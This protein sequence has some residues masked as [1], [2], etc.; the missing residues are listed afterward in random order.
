M[1]KRPI[2][3]SKSRAHSFRDRIDEFITFHPDDFLSFDQF[4]RVIDSWERD[5]S[6]EEAYQYYKERFFQVPGTT[7]RVQEPTDLNKP[8]FRNPSKYI[9]NQ[10][11]EIQPQPTNSFPMKDNKKYQLH[12]IGPRGTYMIDLMFGENGLVYL[13]G[14]NVN[15]RYG[16][17]ELTNMIQK[18]DILK[19]NAKTTTG[20]I[21]ALNKMVR[22]VK[23]MNPITNLIGD[24]EGA[25]TSATAKNFYKEN[26]IN[27]NPVPRMYVDGK[28]TTNPSHSS[29]A[30]VDRFIRTIRDMLYNANYKMTPLAVKAMVNQYNNAPHT[31]LSNV[32]G[33]KVS[34][35]MV[36]QDINKEEYIVMRINKANIATKLSNGYLLNNNTQV[37]VYNEK[38][39]FGKRRQISNI[40]EIIERIGSFY[41][42]KIKTPNGTRIELVPRYKLDPIFISQIEK[43]K[44]DD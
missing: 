25:F 29:L 5:M 22:E 41:K 38:N 44:K 12:K 42:V 14:I 7:V 18:E 20:Y 6:P 33:F 4:M 28:K 43:V 2:T 23:N 9:F 30:I 31:T 1:K 10:G 17:V 40:G 36:Q 35:L 39:V 27:F 21:R 3:R 24:G 8:G 11:F 26:H 15:T 13:V 16:M 34:P 37:K 19:K 32:I